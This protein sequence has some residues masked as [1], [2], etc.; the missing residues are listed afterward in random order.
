MVFILLS[1]FK[2]ENS[3]MKDTPFWPDIDAYQISSKYLKGCKSYG[4]HEVSA[5]KFFHGRANMP[6]CDT[7]S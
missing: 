5:F 2:G 4:V 1:S 7:L 6:A 3:K